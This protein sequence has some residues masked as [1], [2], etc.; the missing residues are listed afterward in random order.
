[1]KMETSFL[2]EV[3]NVG[4]STIAEIGPGE[5]RIIFFDANWAYRNVGEAANA[6]AQG[7][8]V[9]YDISRGV[10][11]PLIASGILLNLASSSADLHTSTENAKTLSILSSIQASWNISVYPYL[12]SVVR[13]EMIKV[14]LKP[15][16]LSAFSVLTKL[17]PIVQL[18]A[19]GMF[20]EASE[21]I[22]TI[23]PDAFFTADRISRYASLMRSADAITE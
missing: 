9:A 22:Q 2:V 11:P 1:M 13:G 19:V 6:L 23:E 8:L 7:T 12:I 10:V 20:R 15:L 21:V 17:G 3:E 18:L 4:E 14:G 16:G 5:S